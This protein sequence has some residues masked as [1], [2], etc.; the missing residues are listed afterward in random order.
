MLKKAAFLW[1]LFLALMACQ[2]IQ[3]KVMPSEE[4]PPHPV[5][6]RWAEAGKCE[7][8]P[9]IFNIY[10]VAWGQNNGIWEDKKDKIRIKAHIGQ[11]NAV[12]IL[13]LTYPQNGKMTISSIYYGES[14]M[15]N[16]KGQLIKCS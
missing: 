12:M 11:D 14:R 13:D 15:N 1:P 6:G 3:N 5:I 10:T 4:T 7:S 8:L 2:N 16:Q 9:W